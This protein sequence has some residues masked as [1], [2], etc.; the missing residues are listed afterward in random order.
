[1]IP[2]FGPPSPPPRRVLPRGLRATLLIVGLL[3]L[4][5]AFLGALLE[6]PAGMRWAVQ[7][8]LDWVRPLPGARVL[9]GGARGGFLT[10]IEL[11][12]LNVVWGTGITHAHIDTL[13]VTYVPSELLGSSIRARSVRVAGITFVTTPELDG[14]LTQTRQRPPDST[15]A[16]AL[17]RLELARGAVSIVRAD[18]SR[19]AA[20]PLNIVGA[21]A[22]DVNVRLDDLRVRGSSPVFASSSIG[23]QWFAPG[24]TAVTA[25]LTAGAAL[26]PGWI[27]DL[28][29][30]L[31]LASSHLALA[32][33]VAVPSGTRFALDHTDIR[34]RLA[35]LSGS[36]LKRLVPKLARA[37]DLSMESRLLGQGDSIAFSAAARTADGARLDAGGRALLAA[38]RPAAV[39]L[40]AN[41]SGVDA[42]SWSLM[43]R[44]ALVLSGAAEADLGGSDVAHLSGPLAL[45][46]DAAGTRQ[47]AHPVHARL[48]ARFKDGEATGRADA[49][50]DQLT[51]HAAG[52]V[53]PLGSRIGCDLDFVAQVPPFDPSWREPGAHGRPL[54]AGRLIGSLQAKRDSAAQATGRAEISFEPGD[55][56]RS[57]VGAGQLKV[58]LAGGA[59]QWQSRLAIESGMVTARGRIVPGP[60]TRYAIQSAE[61]RAVPLGALLG[62]SL[63]STLDAT[64][65]LAGRGF[66]PATL[67]LSGVVAPLSLT[68]GAH[69]AHFDTLQFA[70]HDDRLE[71]RSR[72]VI[73][74]TSLDARGWMRPLTPP[75]RAAGFAVRFEGL[76]GSR[77]RPDTLLGSRLDGTLECTVLAPDLAEWRS[78]ATIS[79][80][81]AER[82]EGT[83]HLALTPSQWRRDRIT[84]LAFDA[85][86]LDGLL[87]YQGRLESTFGRASWTGDARPFGHAREARLTALTLEDVDLARLLPAA[88]PHTRLSGRISAEGAGESVDSLDARWG[89]AL[90]GS[91]VG[92]ERIGR[93]RLSGNLVRGAMDA[94]FEADQGPDSV[95]ARVAARIESG[96][97]ARGWNAAGRI[98]AGARFGGSSLD[99]MSGE[100]ALEGGVL[101]IPR[102]EI[103]GNWMQLSAH[104]RVALGPAAPDDSTDLRITGSTRDL[105]PLGQRLGIEPLQAGTG[106]FALSATGPR[107]AVKLAGWLTATRL[108]AGGTRADSVDVRMDLLA[109]GDSVVHAQARAFAQGLVPGGMPERQVEATLSWNGRELGLDGHA[110]LDIG[111][112]QDLVLRLA[113]GGGIAK[114]WL[115]R[116]DMQRGETHFALERPAIIEFGHD[117]VTVDHLGLMQ[118]GRRCL[119]ASGSVRDDPDSVLTVAIDSLDIAAPL[120]WLD[121]PGLRGR[122][123]AAAEF[124]GPRRSPAVSGWLRGSVATERGRP[125]RL[126]GDMAWKSDSLG[127]G[128]RFAQN[129]RQWIGI[130]ARVPLGLNLDPQP[131]ERML[132]PAEG[133]FDAALEASQLDL[134]W[135]EPLISPRLVRKLAGRMDGSVR[136][137]GTTI[138]PILAGELHVRR[139]RAQV[140]SLATTFESKD[141]GLAFEHRSILLGPSVMTAGGGRLELSGRADLEGPG[142]RTFESRAA[143]KKFRFMNTAL[144]K[145][146]LNGELHAEGTLGRPAV[147]GS[148]EMANTTVY[149]EGGQSDR[150]LE[151][152]ELTE[153]DWRELDARFSE[154]DVA[155]A[156]PFSGLSDSL[157][158]D[159]TIKVGR[160]V[161]VRR[162]SDPIVALELS[163]QVRVT[164]ER[165]EKPEIAGRIDVKTGR[166]YLS[167]LNRRFDLT[168]A[169]VDLPGPIPDATAELEAQYLP[170]SSG[171]GASSGASGPDVTALVTLDASGAR[172]DLHST[173]FMEHAALINYL[174]T[175]QTQGEM[176]SGTA[177]GL[178]VG[179]VL[180]T[181]GGSAGRSLGL[182]V[183]QV[184]QDAYGGQT[185]SA[186]SHVKPQLYLGFRQPVVQGQQSSSRGETGNYTTEFEVEVEAG[187]RMLMNVQGGGS[188]YRFLLRPRLGK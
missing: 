21:R 26:E 53:R 102:L 32:G 65:S 114:L 2:T 155:T 145:V 1:M 119:L 55:S 59:I 27:R 105:K 172:V 22:R 80:A 127:A 111:G 61:A 112:T 18:S 143:F 180:G 36:D 185:L 43:D 181:V 157:R 98:Q 131:G 164:R 154:A 96:R 86:L 5:P 99:T 118:D 146:E 125:A 120:A 29:L 97:S 104:G 138:H 6:F 128:L 17:D 66:S 130:R 41:A 78:P 67:Q 110:E 42:G 83:L 20:G 116:A 153:D 109:S 62:D 15:F 4:V 39:R 168:H 152:V 38:G 137:S 90:D 69:A 33:S 25:T 174:A 124:R 34:L 56:K 163:G 139:V 147:T 94:R 70:L 103:A 63:A 82:A 177:Y 30:H 46:L 74:G 122:V 72:G 165:G 151:T 13:R 117:A 186:G 85:E 107:D 106:D 158:S 135:F 126:E 159:L 7:S 87:R 91:S 150:Q 93:L 160:N 45:S 115:E 10:G 132:R 47:K 19:A 123:S 140:P 44:G 100:F 170:G 162:R 64:L 129:D 31:D 24:D 182:D 142:H 81:R 57:V 108:R 113:R 169:R 166:S 37:P 49:T 75:I 101:R 176:S 173:P 71:V 14:L 187:R 171:T 8:G 133:E 11:H 149:I 175:G 121:L 167:F 156:S 134:A 51:F 84:S 77:F 58:T 16:L 60:Q 52:T 188:Q 12:D 161:W 35:P 184:T 76:D 50:L 183:V 23:A 54:L 179:S 40:R 92:Q 3:A 9:V 144:A 68:R 178:A 79:P 48:A 89:V 73:D 141:L 28:D 148:L 88:I 95:L 136:A